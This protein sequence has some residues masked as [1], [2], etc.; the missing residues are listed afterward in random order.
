MDWETRKTLRAITLEM[1]EVLEGSRD[2][3]GARRPGDL[4]RRLA[5][6]TGRDT[7]TAECVREAALAWAIRLLALR[8]LESRGLIDGGDWPSACRKSDS[9]DLND[10]DSRS[11]NENNCDSRSTSERLL[12]KLAHALPWLFDAALPGLE[13]RP[14]DEALERCA[15]LLW[16]QQAVRGFPVATDAVFQAPGALGWAYQYWNIADKERV[17]AQVREVAGAK[18]RGA[19]IIPATQLYTEDYMVQYLVQNSLGAAWVERHPES[20]LPAQWACF[21][22]ETHPPDRSRAAGCQ[23][24]DTGDNPSGP[25]DASSLTVFDPACGSGHLLLE[26]FDLLYSMHVEAGAAR[27]PDEICRQILER[28]LFGVDIDPWAVRIGQAVL[29]MRARER[30]PGFVGRPTGLIAAVANHFQ[31]PRWETFLK[32]QAIGTQLAGVLRRF[33]ERRADAEEIGSLARPADDLR[34]ILGQESQASADF[35]ATAAAER[36][37]QLAQAALDQFTRQCRQRG[38]LRDGAL[39][40]G[41]AE[42][43]GFR[44]LDLLDRRYDVVVANPPYMGSR[45]MGP[46]LKR[47]VERHYPAGK[48]D[49]FAAFLL[50]CAEWAGDGGRV[51]MITQQS[52]MFLRSFAELRGAAASSRAAE[53]GSPAGLL[54]R[55]T[56]HSLV[57]LGPASF[58][59]IGGE[60]VNTAMFT[61]TARAPSADQR[62]TCFRL[63][64]RE[65]PAEKARALRAA[66][67]GELPEL[68]FRPRQ[69]DLATLPGAPLVYWASPRILRLLHAPATVA[70]VGGVKQGLATG[71]NERFVR[72]RWEC[73]DARRWFRYAKGGGYRK[74]CG[75]EL[76]RVDWQYAGRRVRSLTDASGK[77]RSAVRNDSTY[78]TAGITYTLMAGGALGLR[79]LDDSLYDVASMSVFPAHAAWDRMALMALLNSTAASYFARLLTQELKFNTSYV[80]R[81][82]LPPESFAAALRNCAE[83]CVELKSQLVRADLLEESFDPASLRLVADPGALAI[84]WDATTVAL[85]TWEAAAQRL[86]CEAFGLEASDL[87]AMLDETGQPAGWFPLLAGYDQPPAGV[88]RE[89]TPESWSDGLP[90]HPRQTMSAGQLATLKRRLR[91]AYEA[92]PDARPDPQR[93]EQAASCP[94][95]QGEV[96]VGVVPAG[97]AVPIPPETF[98]E[99]LCQRVRLHPISVHRLVVEGVAN[100]GWS[101]THE[102]RRRL[103]DRISVAVLELLGY[104]WPRFAEPNLPVSASPAGI[105]LL[106]ATDG[107][108]GLCELVARRLR[109]DGGHAAC[110]ENDWDNRSTK[111]ENDWDSRAAKEEND[112]DNRST[113]EE[114]LGMP[115]DAWLGSRFF[116]HHARQFRKRPIAWQI[117]SAAATVARRPALAC[118]LL[119]HRLD[120]TTLPTI[121][122]RYLRPLLRRMEA[123]RSDAT[124]DRLAPNVASRQ[125]RPVRASVQLASLRKLDAALA[126]VIASGFGPPPLVP[127]LRQHAIDE[128]ML[129]LKSRW[130]SR[131]STLIEETAW[132]DWLVAAQ[133]DALPDSLLA[134]I[135]DA[136]LHL[137][138]LGAA[139]GPAPPRQ[140][141]LLV[142]PTSREL[143]RLIGEHAEA[144]TRDALRLACQAWSATW[145]REARAASAVSDAV[146][147]ADW[148]PAVQRLR[149][150]IESWQSDEPRGWTAWLGGGPLFDQVA[151]A[152]GRRLPPSTIAEFIAQESCYEPDLNDGVRVNLAPLQRAGVLAAKVLD[153]DDVDRALADRALW[154]AAERRL[155]REGKLPACGWWPQEAG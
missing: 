17:F 111:E 45:N 150:W 12:V 55:R 23:L 22:R 34:A 66:A 53:S 103:H 106:T 90:D 124:G 24:G 11:T 87:N 149:Q 109:G 130:L 2:S 33:G 68:V 70:D 32:R 137:E 128:A 50:R 126:T 96:D 118:V 16:G 8:C 107:E 1:R 142:D 3:S 21:V 155:V 112:W 71:W 26:A 63:V 88:P 133:R 73:A 114:L 99:A 138:R 120:A 89:S 101:G 93:G 79:L 61:F 52:W 9:N 4:A 46:A 151:S 136:V 19:D 64:A 117:Q 39:A 40:A 30:A 132:H 77:P 82:P 116:R 143:A 35:P 48:R 115:L 69:R 131:L 78:L 119:Y 147:L 6:G 43:D 49:L 125:T 38:E 140:E 28:Q 37:F 145:E 62:F 83:R 95:D 98:L 139:V 54:H 104:R 13:A 110:Q 47:Y 144:M 75:L 123:A 85:H 36:Q 14:S 152:D 41:D 135:R 108:A 27:S 31:G 154:R 10:W 58:E 7:A 15:K 141:Q 121:R 153:H 25:P 86:A 129:A 60:I 20:K 105:F 102:Q 148:K 59:Q 92:G 94:L 100:E 65:N 44:L 56:F 18:I 51:A 113:K 67:A 122:R 74:W 127:L 72:F 97:V 80:T 29:W 84:P 5:A 91:L 57:H 146:K 81:L 76:F 42:G 134:G